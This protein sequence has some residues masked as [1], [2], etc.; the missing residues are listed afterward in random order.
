MYDEHPY[1]E[2][3]SASS[4]FDDDQEGCLADLVTCRCDYCAM[5]VAMKAKQNAGFDVHAFH[6]K[7]C[8]DYTWY[9]CYQ[10]SSIPVPG[11]EMKPTQ[12]V[13]DDDDN[14]EDEEEEDHPC[15]EDHGDGGEH[16]SV[17]YDVF[18]ETY[19]TQ[20]EELSSENFT[21]Y[22][23]A[24]HEFVEASYDHERLFTEPESTPPDEAFGPSFEQD[25]PFDDH[26]QP[27]HS[28]GE[29]EFMKELVD[30]DVH[31]AD[32]VEH[33]LNKGDPA[34]QDTSVD[35][36]MMLP[37]DDGLA[38]GSKQKVHPATQADHHTAHAHHGAAHFDPLDVHVFQG[39]GCADYTWYPCHQYTSIP[40]PGCE[41][42]PH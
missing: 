23:D 18:G 11:C 27:E 41:K 37:G 17:L 1:V 33:A 25:T 9:P 19:F 31:L 14:D 40:V 24:E 13:H 4:L 28:Q 29:Q 32:F 8:A 16:V 20:P 21:V 12:K 26:L 15:D 2:G 38:S 10:Y 22:E 7:G 3:V 39:E 36:S 42:K 35:Y 30:V 6:G 5:K 34:E